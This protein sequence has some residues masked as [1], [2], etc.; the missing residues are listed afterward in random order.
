MQAL[1]Y[2]QRTENF[3][4]HKIN[5]HK[6]DD[7]YSIETKSE[8]SRAIQNNAEKHIPTAQFKD[9][10]SQNVTE[11]GMT[12]QLEKKENLTGMPDDLKEGIESLSG[13]S[14]DDVRVHYNSS[15][16]ATV[17]ALAYTQGTDIHVAPGQEKHLPH[18]AWHVAQQMAGRV[19]PT[20]NINGMPVNDNVEL[21]R[22]ADVMGEM[23]VQCKAD[24]NLDSALK[25]KKYNGIIQMTK[26]RRRKTF[27]WYYENAKDKGIGSRHIASDALYAKYRR[28]R[29]GSAVRMQ[30]MDDYMSDIK[31]VQHVSNNENII[32]VSHGEPISHEKKDNRFADLHYNQLA[33]MVFDI[34]K[35]D[36]KEM[37]NY[38]GEI[39]LD[40]CHTGEPLNKLYDGTSYA[41]RF[42]NVLRDL[43]IKHNTNLTPFGILSHLGKFYMGKSF[44]VKGNLGAVYTESDGREMVKLNSQNKHL[45]EQ[46]A[47]YANHFFRSYEAV[48]ENS[49]QKG[50]PGK[51]YRGSIGKAKYKFYY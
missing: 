41:E 38:Q 36:E 34:I 29:N 4:T 15:K 35:K 14:M 7:M 31:K 13:F 48:R 37:I 23:A 9:N 17:Q 51:Y 32:I 50:F 30:N 12:A 45:F 47:P 40:G 28:E 11:K 39:F 2:T 46:N 24:N 22:E 8:E 20:T 42:G 26:A 1:A 18:E 5:T 6:Q 44:T 21:E 3:N 19:S 43:I 27:I 10:R 16:P 49:G 33:G 25:N